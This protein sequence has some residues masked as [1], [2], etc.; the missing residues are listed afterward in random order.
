MDLDNIYDDIL[1]RKAYRKAYLEIISKTADLLKYIDMDNPFDTSLVFEYL[2]WNGY[3]SKDKKFLYSLSGR[4]CALDALGADIMRGRSVCLNNCDML[5]KIY[6]E[7]NIASKILCCYM[8]EQRYLPKNHSKDYSFFKVPKEQ[9][10]KTPKSDDKMETFMIDHITGNHVVTIFEYNDLRYVV[11]PTNLS[12]LKPCGYKKLKFYG[13]N[14]IMRIR[15]KASIKLNNGGFKSDISKQDSKEF[16]KA[17]FELLLYKRKYNETINE[18][19]ILSKHDKI[20]KFC[21]NNI[22]IF[23]NF[24][25]D[26]KP[27]IDTVCKTLKR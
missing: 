20:L 8:P 26:I 1:T 11:D 13:A 14:N 27:Q 22:D 5:T 23:E 18:K 24:H 6:K 17:M 12:F 15:K 25:E 10:S 19:F 16:N 3:F 21:A 2:L 4:C 7:L 9:V